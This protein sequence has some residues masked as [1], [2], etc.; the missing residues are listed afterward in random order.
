LTLITASHSDVGA[1]TRIDLAKIAGSAATKTNADFVSAAADAPAVPGSYVLAILIE[2]AVSVTIAGKPAAVLPPGKYLYCGSAKGPGGL[3]ARLSRHMR[4]RK[5]IRWHIDQITRHGRVLG[6]WIV[7]DGDECRLVE[8][9][10]HLSK[11]IPGFGST[12]CRRCVAHMLAWP[13][14]ATN[15][16]K[17]EASLPDETRDRRRMGRGETGNQSAQSTP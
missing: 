7:P 3:K 6:A 17:T 5:N 15:P 16:F 9:L 2:T 8:S 11:P 13:S 14:E 12:D 10:S 1:S 4:S